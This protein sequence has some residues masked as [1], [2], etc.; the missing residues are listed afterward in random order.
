MTHHFNDKDNKDKNKFDELKDDFVSTF[1]ADE[2][3][4]AEVKEEGIKKKEVEEGEK[5]KEFD[6]KGSNLNKVG[7]KGASD[8]NAIDTVDSFANVSELKVDL[9]DNYKK[10]KAVKIEFQPKRGPFKFEIE[11]KEFTSGSAKVDNTEVFELDEPVETN[12]V[13]IKSTTGANLEIRD[14]E[15]FVEG[16][17]NEGHDNRNPPAPAPKKSTEDKKKGDKK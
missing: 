14:V 10:V 12:C 13:C 6:F 2:P 9:A 15:V 5:V 4:K 16:D 3:K 1:K 17:P 11:G 8:T 7:I